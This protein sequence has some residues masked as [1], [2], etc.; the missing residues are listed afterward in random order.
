[1]PCH[2]SLDEYLEAWIGAAGIGDDK[3]GPLFRSFKKGDKVTGNP[4]IRSDVL[5]MIK[6][7]AKGAGLPLLHLL[8]YFSR[9]WDYGLSSE[10][11]HARTRSADS[12]ASVT[13]YHET[14]RFENC[15]DEVATRKSDKLKLVWADAVNVFEV[16]SDAAMKRAQTR[17]APRVSASSPAL[18]PD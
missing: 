17:R 15:G 14:L 7:R 1:V 8:S 12:S 5:Y 18:N 9:D 3:K 13:P 6:R 2:H 10:R 16:A 4:M 11:R